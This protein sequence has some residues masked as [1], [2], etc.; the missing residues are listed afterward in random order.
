MGGGSCGKSVKE[1]EMSSLEVLGE[2][3]GGHIGGG[4]GIGLVCLGNHQS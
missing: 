3:R 4:Y 2:G 1:A